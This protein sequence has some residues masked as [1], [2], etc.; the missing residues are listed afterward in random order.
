MPGVLGA[1]AHGCPQADHASQSADY[2]PSKTKE[3]RAIIALVIS[4]LSMF[5]TGLMAYFDGHTIGLVGVAIGA[6]TIFYV[7]VSAAEHK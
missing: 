4:G 3:M 2:L 5:A 6:A 1:S 7:V